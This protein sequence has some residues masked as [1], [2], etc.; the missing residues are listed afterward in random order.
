MV[1][2]PADRFVTVDELPRA[3]SQVADSWPEWSLHDHLIPEPSLGCCQDVFYPDHKHAPVFGSALPGQ[4]RGCHVIVT[5]T[6]N[7]AL[8][9]C[10][11]V[12]GVT[13]DGTNQV[14]APSCRAA[15]RGVIVARVLHTFGHEVVAGGL[16]GQV[17]SADTVHENRQ[18]FP[19]RHLDDRYAPRY[20][21]VLP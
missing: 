7:T 8:D 6:L 4:H 10:Y 1:D 13:W 15:G 19:S 12:E 9:L 2:D 11:E 16:A 20:H 21:G 3:L 18:G 17:G 5:V 14:R